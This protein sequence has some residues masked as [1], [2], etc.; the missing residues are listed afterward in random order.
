L[1]A[2]LHRNALAHHREYAFVLHSQS[3]LRSVFARAVPAA[4]DA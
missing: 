4:F 2:G 1:L 3:H